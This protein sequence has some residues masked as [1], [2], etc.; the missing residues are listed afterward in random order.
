MHPEVLLTCVAVIALVV[1]YRRDAARVQHERGQLFADCLSLFSSYRVEQEGRGYPVLNG[2]YLG[3]RVRL[4]P[5]VDHLAWRKLPVLWLRVTVLQPT[6]FGAVL[7]LLAR[8]TGAEYFSHIYHLEHR[9]EIPARWP[10]EALL[11]T[12]DPERLPALDLL[13]PH[14]P[15]ICDP[16]LKELV[17]SPNGV[18]LIY[19][20][21]EAERAHYATFREI[22]FDVSA[23]KAALAEQ[24]LDAAIA[25]AETVSVPALQRKVA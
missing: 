11:Y 18:R 19:R 16:K 9:L 13:Q 24:V 1:L 15:Q 12:D 5:V 4:E 22:R 7:N 20:V 25:I 23:L 10:Q 3:R 2:T 14:V 17:I 6:R 8:A 21:A